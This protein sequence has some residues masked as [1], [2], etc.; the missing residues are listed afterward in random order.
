MHNPPIIEEI[1]NYREE[2]ARKFA[3]DLGRIVEDAQRMEEGLRKE[4]WNVV[5]LKAIKHQP[6]DIAVCRENEGEYKQ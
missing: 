1:R 3:F 2:H 4:G 6:L 5:T